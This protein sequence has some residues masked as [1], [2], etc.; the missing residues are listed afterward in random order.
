MIFLT[1]KNLKI[2]TYVFL[3]IPKNGYQI[4]AFQIKI[5]MNI[6][7]ESL[8]MAIYLHFDINI[9]YIHTSCLCSCAYTSKVLPIPI[10]NTY[11]GNTVYSNY[12]AAISKNGKSIRGSTRK[13]LCYEPQVT[14]HLEIIPTSHACII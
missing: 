13:L 7:G 10:R 2:W 12:I 6:S 14:T 4:T 1:L 5:W 11:Y 9:S 8:Y 3:K